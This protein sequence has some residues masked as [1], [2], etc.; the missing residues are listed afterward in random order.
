MKFRQT[1][2][3]PIAAA[4]SGFSASSA[5]RIEKDRRLP[6]QRKVRRERRRPDPLADVWQSEIVPILEAAPGLCR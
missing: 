3:V 6:S 1:D 5:Y 4:K 2:T